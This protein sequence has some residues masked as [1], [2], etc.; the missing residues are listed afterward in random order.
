MSE[1]E[2]EV[3]L[4][5]VA[6]TRI[7]EIARDVQYS[8]SSVKAARARVYRVL[9]VHSVAGLRLALSQAIAA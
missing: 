1:L 4:R 8:T 5:T 7:Q 3:A 9:G 6:G 2:C